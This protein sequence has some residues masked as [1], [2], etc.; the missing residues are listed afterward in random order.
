MSWALGAG[1]PV[2]KAHFP[3]VQPTQ[4]PPQA[5]ALQKVGFRGALS[6][7]VGWEGQVRGLPPTLCDLE[8]LQWQ[9]PPLQGLGVVVGGLLRAD[10]A[11]PVPHPR[12]LTPA[13]P[14]CCLEPTKA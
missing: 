6:A 13:I 2:L 3:L 9:L 7:D 1:H 4:L 14:L 10:T 8:R 11:Q 12:H 5:R